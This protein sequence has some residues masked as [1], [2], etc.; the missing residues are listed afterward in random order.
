MQALSQLSY[1]PTRTRTV[2][3]PPR[4]CQS[5]CGN[6]GEENNGLRGVGRN[7]GERCVESRQ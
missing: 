2:R 1:S 3:K 6:K 7:S 4:G 5:K